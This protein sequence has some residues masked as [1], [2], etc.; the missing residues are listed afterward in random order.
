MSEIPYA[1][2]GEALLLRWSESANG[3]TLTLQLDPHVGDQHP[4]KSLKCGPNGQRMQIVAVL[5]ADDEKP[6][7]T[8]DAAKTS[9]KKVG[10][11]GQGAT[12]AKSKEHAG[13]KSRTRMA[14]IKINEQSFQDW[15]G[16]HPQVAA[17]NRRDHA[18]TLLKEKLGIHS[19]KELDVP[20]APAAEAFDRLMTDFDTRSYR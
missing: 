10:S 18:D 3:R 19:K 2:Q 13:K 15:I 14:G 9:A 16:V 5:V 20:G 7:S 1:Y 11:S 4:F 6:I 8:E 17:E 12:A